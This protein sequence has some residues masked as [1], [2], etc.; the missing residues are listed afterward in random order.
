MVPGLIILLF[1]ALIN[2]VFF[3][4]LSQGPLTG[5]AWNSFIPCETERKKGK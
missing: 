1:G 4:S 5:Q 2:A 3:F